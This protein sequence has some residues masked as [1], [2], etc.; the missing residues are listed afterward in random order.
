MD[1]EFNIV[2]II[3]NGLKTNYLIF[4]D[5]RPFLIL[6]G[7]G[8][9]SLK[10]QRVGELLARKG[11][12]V[13]IPDLPGF[14][15]SEVPNSAWGLNNYVDWLKGFIKNF[16][17]FDKGFCLLGHSFGGALSVKFALEEISTK[18]EKLF[19]V[20]GSCVRKKS[21]RKKFFLII[22][23]ILKI[24][25]FL[26]FY[27]ILRRVFYKFLGLKSDYLHLKGIMKETYLKI[28]NEDLSASLS[29]LRLPVTVIWGEKDD[30]LP[31]E[32]GHFISQK[33]KT[34]NLVIIPG[35]SHDLEQ[36]MPEL[37]VEKILENI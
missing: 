28:I 25:S 30:V 10:W 14:G 20:A 15:R 9:N 27:Q 11:F 34:S 2:E 6:H 7:W 36:K 31:V 13:I 19:I 18:T 32:Q 37:L 1:F 35:G 23:K 33:I 5:G 26:P 17:E 8:S 16:P 4:G 24:F 3:I 21:L 29:F 12:K 22:S